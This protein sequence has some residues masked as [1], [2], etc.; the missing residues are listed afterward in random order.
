VA[1]A[2]RTLDA[3]KKIKDFESKNVYINRLAKANSAVFKEM[4]KLSDTA[5][6][7]IVVVALAEDMGLLDE[8]DRQRDFEKAREIARG[9]K[10][11]NYPLGDISETTGLPLQE[12]EAL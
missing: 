9:L 1:E 7:D 12:V 11:K 6:K 3:Y 10:R 4:M 5:I 2:Q 8:R